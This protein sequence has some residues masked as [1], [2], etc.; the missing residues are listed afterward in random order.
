MSLV[1]NN[2][3]YHYSSKNQIMKSRN[4]RKYHIS[5]TDKFHILTYRCLMSTYSCQIP[6][7]SCHSGVALSNSY[8]DMPHYCDITLLHTNIIVIFTMRC[9]IYMYKCHILTHI[10]CYI[11]IILVTFFHRHVIFLHRLVTTFIEMLLS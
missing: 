5:L 9:H 3:L 2:I 11:C 10:L 6:K 4:L 7:K 8:I 1:T